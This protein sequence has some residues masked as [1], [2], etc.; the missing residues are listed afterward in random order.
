M[1]KIILFISIFLICLL[2][3]VNVNAEVWYCEYEQ[4]EIKYRIY[5]DTETEETKL[6]NLT[7]N[8]ANLYQNYNPGEFINNRVFQCPEKMYSNVSNID[9]NGKKNLFISSINSSSDYIEY[10]RNTSSAKKSNYEN[11]TDVSSDSELADIETCEGLLGDVLYQDLQNIFK[12]FKIAAPLLVGIFSIYEY[13]SAILA[14][15]EDDIKKANKKL[16][17]RLILVAVLYFL[18]VI[19]DLLL[20]I[21]ETNSQTCVR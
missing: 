12:I 9:D 3:K 13:V 20:D 6:S 5:I 15:N 1:K 7:P 18:P 8:K 14:K 19:L 16:I 21:L 4:S 11:I 10:K 17:T 2:Y